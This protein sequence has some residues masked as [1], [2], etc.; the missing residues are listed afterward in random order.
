MDMLMPHWR[1]QVERCL[2]TLDDLVDSLLLSRGLL[3]A[4][5]REDWLA[6]YDLLQRRLRATNVANDGDYQR[7]YKAFYVVRKPQAFTDVY[8]SILERE[9][10]NS[11][12]SFETLLFELHHRFGK[13]ESSFTSKLV[14]SIDPNKPVDDSNVRESL[15]LSAPTGNLLQAICNYRCI[16]QAATALTRYD[17]IAMLRESF[18][19]A[20]PDYRHFTDT[21]KLDLFLWQCGA[22]RQKPPTWLLVNKGYGL[23]YGAT[24]D[25]DNRWVIDMEDPEVAEH[26]AATLQFEADFEVRREGYNPDPA[27]AYAHAVTRL[28]PESRILGGL[29]RPLRPPVE[30]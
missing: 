2:E 30:Y 10:N 11:A 29:Y 5:L 21:K 6:K 22:M 24:V 20:F 25:S 12:V 13:V 1:N 23:V 4:G 9:K 19:E 8:F 3:L 17:G 7:A 28:Y 18:D 14:A 16:T 15:G 26:E 27:N